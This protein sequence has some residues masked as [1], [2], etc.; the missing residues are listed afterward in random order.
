MSVF[1]TNLGR[2][3]IFKEGEEIETTHSNLSAVRRKEGD[4]VYLTGIGQGHC[5]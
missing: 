5:A 3:C 2:E 1:D 4:V